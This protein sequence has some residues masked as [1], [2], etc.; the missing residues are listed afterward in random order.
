MSATVL[1]AEPLQPEAEREEFLTGGTRTLSNYAVKFADLLRFDSVQRWLRKRQPA[2]KAQYLYQF[3]RLLA[4]TEKQIGVGTPDKLLAWAKNQKDGLEVQDLIDRYADSVTK[5]TGHM[6]T[7]LVRSF[8]SRNG[9]VGLPKIDWEPTLGDGEGYRREELLTLLE[10]LDDPLQKL[11]VKVIVDSG[12]RAN[13]ALY[14]RYRHIKEDLEAGKEYVAVRFEKE[15]Y[16]K[17]KSPGRSFLGPQSLK[18]LRELI[19]S[20]KVKTDL[21]AKIFPFPYRTITYY[22]DQAKRRGN[23]NPKLA[24]SHGVRKFY[25]YSLDRADP[26]IDFHRKMLLEGHSLHIRSAYTSKDLELLRSEYARTYRYRDLS[27]QAVV[28]TEV[29]DLQS[30]VRRLKEELARKDKDLPDVLEELRR[31]KKRVQ[32]LETSK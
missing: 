9:F 13:D 16:S 14:L 20:G 11:Y 7:A 15:R 31:L 22:L 6:A 3:S 1:V 27:E 24:P 30:E 4:W 2:T 25:T 29:T 12:F 32:E 26:P 21:N 10:Y 19:K 17:R 18:L 5:S 23:L 28:S 8:L